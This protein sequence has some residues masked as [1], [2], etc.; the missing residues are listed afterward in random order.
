MGTEETARKTA[1]DRRLALR[2]L[3]EIHSLLGGECARCGFADARA[4]QL[5]H[6]QGGGAR[7]LRKSGNR[8]FQYQRVLRSV[9]AGE[10]VYQ[11]LCANC[12]WIKRAERGE[13]P[14]QLLARR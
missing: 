9:K 8:R 1:G 4:L 2:L 10:M 14:T 3:G 7:E 6:I 12:N 11:L 5:D 13:G